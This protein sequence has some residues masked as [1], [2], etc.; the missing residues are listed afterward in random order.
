MAKRLDRLDGASLEA[1]T[2]KPGDFSMNDYR[3]PQ[4]NFR[5]PWDAGGGEPTYRA[6]LAF[7][8]GHGGPGRCV[9][10]AA[11]SQ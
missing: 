1:W 7:A 4:G 6:D 8:T 9:A 11:V 3:L 2:C 5:R 10:A